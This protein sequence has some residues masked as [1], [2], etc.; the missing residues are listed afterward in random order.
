VQGCPDPISSNLYEGSETSQIPA[1]ALLASLG[2]G[3]PTALA[4][5]K[6]GETVLNLGSGEA[7]TFCCQQSGWAPGARLM[8]W[9]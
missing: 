6:P 7:L 2:C 3:K 5:L 8:V 9:T 4:E 1:E